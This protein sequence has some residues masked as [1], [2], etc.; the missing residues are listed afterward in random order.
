MS[1]AHPDPADLEL[2]MRGELGK[3]ERRAIVRHLLTGCP[4]C[5]L[6]TRNYWRRGDQ[7]YALR[8]LVEEALALQAQASRPVPF[9]LRWGRREEP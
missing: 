2:F 9:R 3:T 7:P 6:V 4:E 1:R 5:V 8:V